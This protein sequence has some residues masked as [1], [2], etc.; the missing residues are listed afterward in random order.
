MHAVY[1]SV[2]VFELILL[3]CLFIIDQN[4]NFVSSLAALSNMGCINS[5]E[6]T[7][8]TLM[9]AS[10]SGLADSFVETNSASKDF[11]DNLIMSYER[12]GNFLLNTAK[13][14]DKLKSKT[15]HKVSDS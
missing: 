5:L 7:L 12:A 2:N 10:F 1:N 14:L 8:S 15:L 3:H 4:G 13:M 6:E 11:F 9:E